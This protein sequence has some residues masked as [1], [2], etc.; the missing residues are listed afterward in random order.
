MGGSGKPIRFGLIES[1]GRYG[2]DLN[3][4]EPGLVKTSDE[5]GSDED[6]DIEMEDLALH[7]DVDVE[8]SAG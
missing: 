7:D 8:A 6:D 4:G 2:I 5:M 3:L 1:A